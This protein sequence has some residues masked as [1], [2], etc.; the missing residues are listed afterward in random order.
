MESGKIYKIT[1]KVNNKVYIGC[2]I[3]PLETRF[4]E[5]NYRCFKL[6]YISKLYNSI[7]KY[8]FDN[9]IIELIEECPINEMFNREKKYIQQYDSFNTGLNLTKGGE[10]VLGYTHSKEIRKK[11]SD[12]LND[13]NPHKDKTYEMIYGEN[14][15]LEKEKR[16]NS[17]KKYWENMSEDEKQKRIK[18]QTIKSRENSKYGIELIKKIKENISNGYTIKDFNREYPYMSTSYYYSLKNN[19]RWKEI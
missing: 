9:F 12:K 11:I 2:T 7:K 4:Y 15:F 3:K 14:Q 6:N 10:G 8:G 1:N 5:H 18:Q 17:V 19:T 13:N 16:K